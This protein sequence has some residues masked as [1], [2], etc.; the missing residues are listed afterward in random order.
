MARAIA[1]GVEEEWI[2]G[3][4]EI[5]LRP[6]LVFSLRVS[7]RVLAER[8]LLKKRM[9]DYW[10]SGQDIESRGNLYDGFIRYQKEIQKIFKR[11]EREYSLVPVNGER[12]PLEVHREI[13]SQVLQLLR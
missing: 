5:A 1:R 13:G 12:D 6:D 11:F 3:L 4:Y 8:N 9:V 7:P 2:K 10:E